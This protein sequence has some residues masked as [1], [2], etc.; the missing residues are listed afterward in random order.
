MRSVTCLRHRQTRLPR[1]GAGSAG[2]ITAN[3]DLSAPDRSQDHHD[4][5]K[6]SP[7]LHR[8]DMVQSFG[9][10][11][12]GVSR[13]WRLVGLPLASGALSQ[14]RSPRAR[15]LLRPARLYRGFRGRRRRAIQV[16]L[17]LVGTR[18]ASFQPYP[19]G[20]DHGLAHSPKHSARRRPLDRRHCWRPTTTSSPVSTRPCA[21][22]YVAYRLLIAGTADPDATRI[23]KSS[24]PLA[25]R[26]VG[27]P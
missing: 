23:Q 14:Q 1:S 13:G 24:N 19:P 18:S 9:K 11:A 26:S 10:D 22:A 6:L 16:D 25:P 5:V 8:P 27:S 3:R 12:I 4:I 20:N 17:V 7:L 21:P 2:P 15:V